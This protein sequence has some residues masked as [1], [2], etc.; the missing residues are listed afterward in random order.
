MT[1]YTFLSTITI[2]TDHYINW[3]HN[4]YY[5]DLTHR[6]YWPYQNGG[7]L[8]TC[9]DLAHPAASR[10]ESDIQAQKHGVASKVSTNL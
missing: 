10:P 8:W 6:L 1:E 5:N 3:L 2:Y 4:C 9:F 7:G